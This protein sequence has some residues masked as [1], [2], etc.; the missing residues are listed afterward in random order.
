MGLAFME[1]S[2]GPKAGHHRWYKITDGEG[3]CARCRESG[4]IFLGSFNL[5]QLKNS[6]QL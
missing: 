3:G 4:L 2:S 6:G 1:G 5:L